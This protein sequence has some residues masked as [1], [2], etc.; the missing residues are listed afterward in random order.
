MFTLSQPQLP[1]LEYSW[2]SLIASV[3]SQHS[4]WILCLSFLL[5]NGFITWA[6]M[7]KLSVF[8]FFCLASFTFLQTRSH[9]VCS[10]LGLALLSNIMLLGFIYVIHCFYHFIISV[11]WPYNNFISLFLL[12]AG[13]LS[14][15]WYYKENC[16]KHFTYLAVTWRF[17]ARVSLGDTPRS[18]ISELQG[19]QCSTLEDNAKQDT[20]VVVP[21]YTPSMGIASPAL[22]MVRLPNFCQ[23]IG[24]NF[25]LFLFDC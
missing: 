8:S 11:M 24:Y 6:C 18:K 25:L 9:I 21:V 1:D 23:P 22:D 3:F 5:K 16:Y 14:A 19:M 4:L 20:K 10:F 12:D 15:F 13:W 7:P 17:W 2:N